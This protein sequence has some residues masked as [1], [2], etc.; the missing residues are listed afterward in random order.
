MIGRQP[1]INILLT[2]I[3]AASTAWSGVPDGATCCRQAGVPS[4]QAARLGLET[5]PHKPCCCHGQSHVTGVCACHVTKLPA[6][7]CET[8]TSGRQAWDWFTTSLPVILPAAEVADVGTSY[9][10]DRLAH[11]GASS[12]AVHAQLCNWRI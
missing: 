2:P 5:A 1:L 10:C 4:S 7:P 3:L 11:Y 9:S 12:G 8:V 6:T